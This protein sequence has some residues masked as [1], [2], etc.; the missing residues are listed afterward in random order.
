MV[1]LIAR[2]KRRAGLVGDNS[3]PDTD[4]QEAISEMYGELHGIV[5]DA[6][7]RYYETEAS[8]TATGA[9]SYALPTDHW[10]IGQV[11]KSW[12][13]DL[14]QIGS[15]LYEFSA[16]FI[17]AKMVTIDDQVALLGSANMDERSYH[18]NFECGVL[19]YDRLCTN[20]WTEIFSSMIAE[21]QRFSLQK[22]EKQSVILNVRDGLFRILSP[23]I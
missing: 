1:T 10:L 5:A 19:L 2:C 3:I 13:R 15:E 21:A 6:G 20:Q 14:L 12:Y 17:H 4:W 11:G 23:I 8:I 9:S 22:L 7:G 18:L 16:Y